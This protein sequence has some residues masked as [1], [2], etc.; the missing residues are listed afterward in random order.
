MYMHIDI[1]LCSGAWT[2]VFGAVHW[3]WRVWDLLASVLWFWGGVWGV[4]PYRRRTK[5]ALHPK[6]QPGNESCQ[7][8][9][10]SFLLSHLVWMLN[11]T[12]LWLELLF[13][14]LLDIQWQENPG[15][16]TCMDSRTHGLQT[17]QSVCFKEINGMSELNG[18]TH[19]VTGINTN[20]TVIMHS[21]VLY[22]HIKLCVCI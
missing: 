6:H 12:V 2:C 19:Q 18:T 5:R 9:I 21:D 13:N 4:G 1:T 8:F 20:S 14:F 22:L 16:V 3:L 10:R 17:G 11:F 7:T 15:V